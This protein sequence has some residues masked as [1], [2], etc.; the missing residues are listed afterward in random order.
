MWTITAT[1]AQS[2]VHPGTREAGCPGALFHLPRRSPRRSR[3]PG[4]ERQRQL[5]A[6]AAGTASSDST[7][8]FRSPCRCQAPPQMCRLRAPMRFRRCLAPGERVRDVLK[9][10][11]PAHRALS[12]PGRVGGN[13]Q[14]LTF[15]FQ[16]QGAWSGTPAHHA[17]F[18]PGGRRNLQSA[19]R[20]SQ[21]EGGGAFNVER[22]TPTGKPLLLRDVDLHLAL[23]RGLGGGIRHCEFPGLIYP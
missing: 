18:A 19:I 9:D 21:W 3:A 5:S 16:L 6:T 20:N 10:G 23:H 22:V 17:H 13:V 4:P 1:I 11:T 12:R 2:W 14:R 7:L 15:N 8:A